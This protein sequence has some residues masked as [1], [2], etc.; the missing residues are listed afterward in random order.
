MNAPAIDHARLLDRLQRLGAVG[1]TASG[2]LSRLALT[3]ADREGRDLLAGWMRE[4]GLEV[5]VDRIGNIF[6]LWPVSQVADP[7]MIGSHID[8]VIDAGIYDG[9]YGVLAG[10]AV[11]EALRQAGAAPARPIAVAAFTN[12]EGVRFQPDM[13]G[14][15]VHAGGLDIDAALAAVDSDGCVLGEELARIGYAGDLAPGAIRP[16]CYLELHIEQ[17]PVLEAAGLAIGAVDSLQGISWQRVTIEGA[18]NH[19]GTTPIA[20]RRDAGLAAARVI[21]HLRDRVAG[22]N[23]GTLATVGSLRF[24]PDAINVIPSRAVFTVDLRDP[25]EERLQAAED[26]LA[27][28]LEGLAESEGVTVATERL[29]RFQPVRFDPALVGLVAAAAGRRGLGHR[30]MTSGA[31]HDAQ[32]IARIAPAAMIFVPSRGG[33]SHNPAEFTAPADLAAGADVLL[34]VVAELIEA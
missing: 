1:R 3:D 20:A 7:V 26:S 28:F 12:E 4:A 13:M 2:A 17:G 16:H 18:A 19:A 21:A 9:C 34:D 23:A 14:S 6:G 30:R 24:E 15:L 31:G 10:L 33:I 22:A 5:R 29:A 25:E 32:M 8:S 11:V 27:R